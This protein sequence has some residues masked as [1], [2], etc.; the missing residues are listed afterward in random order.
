MLAEGLGLRQAHVS[1]VVVE[2]HASFA[3]G[4]LR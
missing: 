2:I 4:I 1:G 3:T